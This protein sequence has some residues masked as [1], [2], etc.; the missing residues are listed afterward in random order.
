MYKWPSKCHIAAWDDASSVLSINKSPVTLPT[1]ADCRQVNSI[2][3][4]GE[5]CRSGISPKRQ[6]HS[7][8]V[9]MKLQVAFTEWRGKVANYN[10][11]TISMEMKA[12]IIIDLVNALKE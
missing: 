11:S 6:R 12:L 7:W 2:K 5:Q 3:S 8:D 4:T 10:E 9:T 1:V